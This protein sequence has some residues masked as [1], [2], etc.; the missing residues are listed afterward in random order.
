MC[1][2]SNSISSSGNGR[3]TQE[4]GNKVLFKYK[5]SILLQRMK[6]FEAEFRR[7]SFSS[8]LCGLIGCKMI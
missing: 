6:L 5:L 1:V 3:H 4:F 8:S 2:C 7:I